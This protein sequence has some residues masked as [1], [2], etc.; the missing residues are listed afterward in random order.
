MH[1]KLWFG[2]LKERNNLEALCVDGRI[3]LKWIVNQY[4]G[5]TWAGTDM[6]HDRYKWR[7]LLN[8]VMNIRFPEHAGNFLTS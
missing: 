5:S 2:N 4:D 8:A 7:A 3:I 1:A 6:V